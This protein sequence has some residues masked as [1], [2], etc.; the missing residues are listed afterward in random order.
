MKWFE[1]ACF[2]TLPASAALLVSAAQTDDSFSGSCKP[3][4]VQSIDA[5]DRPNHTYVVA[6]AKC[7]L[8]GKIGGTMARQGAVAEHGEITP[9]RIK[10]S[11]IMSL[12]GG[13]FDRRSIRWFGTLGQVSEWVAYQQS[14]DKLQPLVHP[15][16]LHN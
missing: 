4:P 5:G 6:T 15:A 11:G 7:T 16:T 1:I 9:A 10:T 13:S 3:G 14:G 12:A 8:S 2:A